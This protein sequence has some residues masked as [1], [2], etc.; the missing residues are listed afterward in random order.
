MFFKMEGRG[1]SELG[2]SLRKEKGENSHMLVRFRGL[3]SAQRVNTCEN[4]GAPHRC[5]DISEL[6]ASFKNTIYWYV[7]YYMNLQWTLCRKAALLFE[8]KNNSG[9]NTC[10]W[11]LLVVCVI[12]LFCWY[13]TVYK[14]L[15]SWLS[16]TLWGEPRDTASVHREGN[17]VTDIFSGLP[18][19]Y[20]LNPWAASR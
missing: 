6:R 9:K 13:F 5:A 16:L 4:Y 11:K 15:Q 1:S 19:G 10:R 8:K 2:R 17:W 20:F 18:Y 7:S 12:Y 14:R 3:F